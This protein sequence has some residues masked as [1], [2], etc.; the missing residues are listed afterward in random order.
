VAT[1][2][3]KENQALYR[4]NGGFSSE[5]LMDL[6]KMF[7]H[8]DTDGSGDLAKKELITLLEQLMPK[9]AKD[10][11]ER[12][13]LIKL[14]DEVDENGDG[15]LDFQEFVRLVRQAHDF[16]TM[17][18]LSKESKAMTDTGFEL[19]EVQ[20][21]RD[22][23]TKTSN[24]SRELHFNGI[25][26]IMMRV[27]PMGSKQT[28]DFLVICIDTVKGAKH[29]EATGHHHHHSHHGPRRISLSDIEDKDLFF[30]FPDF[31]RLMKQVID[32]NFASVQERFGLGPHAVHHQSAIRSRKSLALRRQA[33]RAH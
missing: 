6:R 27:C 14:I 23:F 11:D 29:G 30:D 4:K 5:D 10:P 20:G 3:R 17:A 9:Y 15:G 31:L 7:A 1:R 18:R 21:F 32:S 33:T 12:P 22:V 13:T 2:K 24:G 16:E 25:K 26:D 28:E 19:H 8:F